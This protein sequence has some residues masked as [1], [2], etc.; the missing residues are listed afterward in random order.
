MPQKYKL[1]LKIQTNS[2]KIFIDKLIIIH[3]FKMYE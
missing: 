1:Y 3:K 2:E